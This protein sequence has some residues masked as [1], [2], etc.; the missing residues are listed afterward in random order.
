M[1]SGVVPIIFTPA[2]L[3]RHSEIE[4]RLA[5]ELDDDTVR[6][7]TLGNIEH[8][9]KGKGFKIE[10]VR[11]I[12]VGA[13]RFR[14]AVHHNRFVPEVFQRKGGMDTAVVEFDALPYPVRSA[15]EDHDLFPV[16]WP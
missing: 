7:F 1:L 13:H 8:I 15:A 9:L 3:K 10:F 5:A 6:L 11:R 2:R 4:R 14:V 12:I 16:R